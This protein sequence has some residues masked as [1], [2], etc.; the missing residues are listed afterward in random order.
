[1]CIVN[2]NNGKNEES[3]VNVESGG[4]FTR[5]M[6]KAE[7]ASVSSWYIERLTSIYIGNK[8]PFMYAE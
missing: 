8:V 5:L 3:E 4:P 2:I 1:M 7:A 6:K